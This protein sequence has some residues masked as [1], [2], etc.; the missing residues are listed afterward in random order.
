[1]KSSYMKLLFWISI[2]GV[3]YSYFIYPVILLLLPKRQRSCSGNETYEPQV[4]L[5][6]TAFNEEKRI[7]EKLINT[8]ELTYPASKLEILIASDASDDNTDNIIKSYEDK[9][10]RL[11]RTEHRKGKENAQK[12]AVQS[13]KGEILVFSDVATKLQADSIQ[14]IVSNFSNE[15]I[16]AVSSVD[17]FISNDGKLVG[18]GA[19][20]KYEMW[21]RDLESSV[22]SL[23]G[24]SG[25]FFAARRV[26]CE[27]WDISIPSDFNT[28]LNSVRKK[29]V[30]I[31]DNNSIGYY[32]NI[33]DDSKEYQRKYR[34]AIRGMS[35]VVK[36]IDVLNVFR[37]GLFS[38]QVWSHKV[39]RWLVPWFMLG[40]IVSSFYLRGEMFIYALVGGVQLFFYSLALVGFVSKSMRH[41]FL[42]KISYFF[43]Q[44]NIAIA[45]AAI[46]F[47]SGKRV[48][49][50][51]PS[52][53]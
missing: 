32:A 36:K 3:T 15:D 16:G 33:K 23:V 31:S 39:M 2:V 42:F 11:V 26:V 51:K 19:Y 9:G 21:L 6:I 52:K 47:F 5:I 20:V 12:L 44:V 43:M 34:T 50:W 29:Y 48:T 17:K 49:T 7:E 38:F 10:I 41:Y 13:S 28:A 4:T 53:R 35:A 24:L 46:A 30:S 14:I 37:Y 8:L 25:S 27:E 18:E 40:L 22:N 1:M 45:H